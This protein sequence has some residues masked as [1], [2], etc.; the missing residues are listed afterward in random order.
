MLVKR[1]YLRNL[2]I[3]MYTL[4]VLIIIDKI[5]EKFGPLAVILFTRI[6]KLSKDN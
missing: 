3:I 5:L 1:D 6:E 2:Q 4:L